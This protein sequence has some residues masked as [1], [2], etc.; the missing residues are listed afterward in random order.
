MEK[1]AESL[2]ESEK[3]HRTCSV[4]ME[5]APGKG[6]WEGVLAESQGP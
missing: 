3:L 2:R 4:D 6:G 5:R 1:A